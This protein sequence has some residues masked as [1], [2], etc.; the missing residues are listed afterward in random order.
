M[1]QPERPFTHTLFLCVLIRSG[2]A[3][4]KRLKDRDGYLGRIAKAPP[5]PST[6]SGK[7]TYD[8]EWVLGG[9]S[10]GV[11]RSDLV[12]TTAQAEGMTEDASRNRRNKRKPADFMEEVTEQDASKREVRKK[13]A[14]VVVK[15]KIKVVA[16]VVPKKLKSVPRKRTLPKKLQDVPKKKAN[17]VK[18]K[19]VKRKVADANKPKVGKKRKLAEVPPPE[20]APTAST[21]LALDVYERHRREFERIVT[22][23]EKV[24]QFGFFFDEAPDEFDEKY[25]DEPET[26]TDAS[27]KLKEESSGAATSG[28]DNGAAAEKPVKKAPVFPS[29]PPY[30]WDMVRRRMENGR[31]IA[32]RE[33]FEKLKRLKQLGPYYASLGKNVLSNKLRPGKDVTENPR[34]LHPKGID[35]NMFRDDVLAMCHDAIDRDSEDSTG[36]SGSITFSANKVKEVRRYLRRVDWV[37]SVLFVVL[38]SLLSFC[39]IHRLYCKHTRGRVKNNWWKCRSQTIATSS[40]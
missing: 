11:C 34:V 8:I 14:A 38:R 9:R 12:H 23:L 36:A 40:Q 6:S 20:L 4:A 31:Y 21:S 7:E 27:N 1:Y 16:K 3:S 19:V 22:R 26:D 18:P 30:N 32:D 5:T 17:D 10:M 15:K 33:K 39:H 2:I 29:H 28:A 13:K 25:A 24:D 35:W 37:E